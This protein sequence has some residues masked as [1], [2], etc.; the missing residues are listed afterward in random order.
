MAIV[1]SN[2]LIAEPFERF[3][4]PIKFP[5]IRSCP[6]AQD[7]TPKTEEQ[8][9]QYATAECL[10]KHLAPYYSFPH[11]ER[12]FKFFCLAST[13]EAFSK[14]GEALTY[15][16]GIKAPISTHKKTVKPEV[17]F[18][19]R[20]A[21]AGCGVSHAVVAAIWLEHGNWPAKLD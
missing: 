5:S 13:R 18:Q 2:L 4:N 1:R 6:V 9:S 12:R 7:A 20:G 16:L 19:E 17:T 11:S 8:K 21:E 3:Y 10:R 15:Y 14:M